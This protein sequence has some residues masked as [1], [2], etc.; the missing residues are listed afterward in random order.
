M[1]EKEGEK[2]QSIINVGPLEIVDKCIGSKVWIIMKGDKEIVK[3]INPQKKYQKKN[4]EKKRT[5]PFQ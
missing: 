4:Y 5:F 3:K 1:N 2:S